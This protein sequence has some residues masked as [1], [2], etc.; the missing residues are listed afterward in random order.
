[1]SIAQVIPMH[2][3]M[4][5]KVCLALKNKPTLEAVLTLSEDFPVFPVRIWWNKGKL[6]KAPAIS[7]Q[8]GGSGHLDAVKGDPEAVK[9][10]FARAPKWNAIGIPTGERSGF[11]V[12]DLDLQHETA[13]AWKEQHPLPVTAWQDTPSGGTHVFL[14][15]RD[16]QKNLT[17]CP[18]KGVDVRGEG[19]WIVEWNLHGLDGD[20]DTDVAAWPDNI[21]IPLEQSKKNLAEIA[22]V[23][24]AQ[25]KAGRSNDKT[26][27]S[28]LT[29]AIMGGI[30]V[31]M[32][33]PEGL[34]EGERDDKLFRWAC[35]LFGRGKTRDEVLADC[36][37]RNDGFKPPLDAS[38]VLKIVDSAA[39][40][41]KP[42]AK[43]HWPDGL[44]KEKH[45]PAKTYPNTRAAII[46]LDVRCQYDEFHD[47]KLIA[48]AVLGGLA[49]KVSDQGCAVLRQAI[50]DKFGFDPG[51]DHVDDAVNELC[52]ENRFDP[53]RDKLDAMQKAWDGK[54]R[55]GT[56][57]IDYAHAADTELTR[58]IGGIMFMAGA[59][60]V[61]QPGAKF[62]IIVVL[63]SPE[64]FNKSK[65][66]RLM[67]LDDENFTDQTL[68]GLT[69]E[70]QCERI[71]GRLICEIPDLAGMKRTEIEHIK[72]FASRQIDRV[73]LAWGRN[74]QDYPRRG[75]FVATTNDSNYLRSQTGNRRFVPIGVGRIDID[76]FVQDLP[77]LWGEAAHW[78]ANGAPIE[79]PPDFWSDAAKEQ[80]ARQELNPWEATLEPV[81]GQPHDIIDERGQPCTEHR[82]HTRELWTLLDVKGAQ[83]TASLAKQLKR[84]ME[85]LG[86]E[87]TEQ[88]LRITINGKAGPPGQG[89]R[90]RIYPDQSDG[91]SDG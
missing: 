8:N 54:K 1:M 90:K 22:A 26:T 86:W 32:A 10:L 66:L 44:N 70:K 57:L 37:A 27:P 2:A 51:K 33:P 17:S 79:L 29:A 5:E 61:R 84:T 64:G 6:E 41:E 3:T 13:G 18:V 88:K 65:L 75:I 38:Q 82:V 55:L 87:Y 80:A 28:A 83:Q 42:A 53:V 23:S 36:R 69:D 24:F 25:F 35:S 74:V 89:Y 68:L 71:K 30:D 62:D 52:W 31:A 81:T 77:Q 58:A 78:E 19:G 46:G 60:R 50:Y 67:A 63:E 4:P 43:I 15:H 39:K 59:R 12:L 45:R 14:K 56:W 16:G 76:K 47:N 9:T 20:V 72:A 73:R 40:Y 91:Q 7:K 21:D 34:K 11:D 48:G 85:T 49:G